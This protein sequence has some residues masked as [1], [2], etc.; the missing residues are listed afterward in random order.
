MERRKRGEREKLVVSSHW[1]HLQVT[2]HSLTHS[3]SLSSAQH[4]KHS[5]PL[6]SPSEAVSEKMMQ[7]PFS[8]P[9]YRQGNPNVL[10]IPAALVVKPVC[11]L[12]WG[13]WTPCYPD[14]GGHIE[15]LWVHQRLRAAIWDCGSWR[16][17][18]FF[19]LTDSNPL[20]FY[21]QSK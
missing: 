13:P 9:S 6:V 3:C 21:T 11:S 4:L 1:S 5:P 19:I 12:Q 15:C 14:K 18:S 7:V 8:H 10:L 16:K 20:C 2:W 17:K